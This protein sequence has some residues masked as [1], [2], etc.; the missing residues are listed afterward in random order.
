MLIAFNIAWPRA[1][2]ATAPSG[3]SGFGAYEFIGASIIVGALY[4]FTV[5]RHKG[6]AV[7]AEHRAEVADFARR[8]RPLGELAP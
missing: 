6:D 5:Q 2:V 3:T 1:A 4:Y 8:S 7:L